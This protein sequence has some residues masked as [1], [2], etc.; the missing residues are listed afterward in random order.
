MKK[1]LLPLC[2]VANTAWADP[3]SVGQEELAFSSFENDQLK[4]LSVTQLTSA[5]AR[6]GGLS[7][8]LSLGEDMIAVSDRGQLFVFSQGDFSKAEVTALLDRDGQAF[9]KKKYRDAESLAVASDGSFWVSFERKHRVV[10][11]D[12]K[13]RVL[14]EAKLPQA[15]TGLP[16][17]GG[18]EAI[19]SLQDGR[20]V[21]IGEGKAD[22]SS[23]PVWVQG[24]DRRW[25]YFEIENKGRFRPTGLARIP[26]T[27][28]LILLERFY[29]PL[30]GTR[31]R[32]SELDIH[33]G[34]RGAVLA[35]LDKPLPIDN[36][37]GLSVGANGVI[38]LV[39]D[40]NFSVLQRTLVMKILLR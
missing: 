36:F 17:N 3:I 8:L 35:R 23:F 11:Y 32:L 19:E 27:D 34:E 16:K 13:G 40:D 37:E 22:F 31:I 15:I 6:L 14:E 25:T 7:G 1:W 10:R 12:L 2:L 33:A 4:L 38:T 29:S 20:L 30:I 9:E 21:L 26:K 5:D 18:L 39:A 24:E 28:R